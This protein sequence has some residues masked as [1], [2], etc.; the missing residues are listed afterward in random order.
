MRMGT[1]CCS[2]LQPSPVSE[3]HTVGE[4]QIS[5]APE[6]SERKCKQLQYNKNSFDVAI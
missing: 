6:F 1:S 4:R 2:V 5:T 3:V